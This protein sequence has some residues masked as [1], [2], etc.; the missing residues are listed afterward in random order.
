MKVCQLCAIDF[1]L[2]KFI[3]PLVDGMQDEGWDVHCVCSDGKFIPDL[4]NQGYKI[5]NIEI[6]RSINPFRHILAVINLYNLFRIEKFDVVHVHTPVAS[7]VGRLAAWLAGIPMI[8]YTAHGFYFH[9]EMPFY[10]K[11]VFILLERISGVITDFLFTQSSEDFQTA[12]DLGIIKPD[13]A[14]AIGNG[15]DVQKYNPNKYLDLGELKYSLAIP[16]DAFVVGMIS[17]LVKEKGIIEFLEAAERL[18]HYNPDL[19]FLLI[20]ERLN[21]DHALGVDEVLELS[22]AKLGKNLVL[23][24]LRSDIPE[25]ISLMDVFCLPSWREGMPRTII[26][27]MMMQKPV[28]ATDIRGSR[29]EVDNNE[30]GLL[31][32]LYDSKKLAEAIN[33]MKSNPNWAAELGKAGRNKALKKYD[34]SKIIS[35]QIKKIT[36]LSSQNLEKNS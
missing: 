18:H 25:L 33:Q 27:A 19:Y 35:I 17:R 30:T 14:L 29:E 6:S 24:G 16:D 9:D 13:R 8:V 34:E 5:I 20:G 4:L 7:L 28:I 2:K 22:K 21:S 26:E 32:P 31:V 15:V 3:I 1:T 10:K 36:E 12:I 23:T 11:W